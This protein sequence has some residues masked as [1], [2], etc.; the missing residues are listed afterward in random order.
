MTPDER[1]APTSQ[2]VDAEIAEGVYDRVPMK[3]EQPPV[4]PARLRDIA[5]R[6]LDTAVG[7]ELRALA[8]WLERR[9]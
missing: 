4:T 6:R 2:L 9:Q 7:D 5:H 3:P 1:P 8:D